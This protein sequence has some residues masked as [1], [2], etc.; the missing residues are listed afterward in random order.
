[1]AWTIEFDPFA[2]K[3]LAKLSKTDALRIRNF[4]RERLAPLE[5]PRSLGLALQGA[6]FAGVWRYRVGDYRV[7]CE[8]QDDRVVVLVVAIAH[9]RDV[10]R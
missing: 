8:I 9:R 10:Y 2:A 6:R 3:Q 7:L 5:N 1:L 4:L